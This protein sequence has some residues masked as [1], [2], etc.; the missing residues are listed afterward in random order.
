MDKANKAI[1]G[2]VAILA[3]GVFVICAGTAGYLLGTRQAQQRG[4]FPFRLTYRKA[5]TGSGYVEQFHNIS[6]RPQSAKV[7]LYN[8]T[9]N[10]TKVYSV[11]VDP[12]DF[13]EIGYL[14]G[15]TFTAG[16]KITVE[17]NGDAYFFIVP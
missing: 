13:K 6:R 11:V 12:R 17:C 9:I 7:T 2:V 5:L 16:D 4:Q 1:L 15:W 14:Q 10:L 3:V 8:P